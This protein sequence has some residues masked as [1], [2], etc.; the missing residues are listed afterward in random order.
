M[1]YFGNPLYPTS[2]ANQQAVVSITGTTTLGAGAATYDKQ[3]IISGAGG[4][5]ITLPAIDATNFPSRSY[6]IFNNSSATCT[7]NAA[8]A[9]TMLLLGS[10]FSSISI[11]PGERF[12]V[13]NML[14]GWVIALESASRTTTASQFDNTI[15]SASTA[16]VISAGLHYP[17]ANGQSFTANGNISISS[18]NGWGQFGAAGVTATLPALSLVPVGTTFTALGGAF[19][20][21]VAA[22]GTD[23]I[24]STIGTNSSSAV[25][26]SGQQVTFVSNGVAAGWYMAS[27]GLGIGAFG[28]SL[29]G[30]GYQKLPSGLIIQ[31]ANS[32]YTGASDSTQTFNF[33]IAFPTSCFAIAGSIGASL[34]AGSFGFQVVNSSQ[35]QVGYHN[36]SGTAASGVGYYWTAFGK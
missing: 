16:Y 33:P 10:S 7:V 13:Q 17:Q 15:R 22:N 23:T 26:I 25:L 27:S 11:L 12:L 2:P 14:T 6:S 29:S 28:S 20:G 18:M 9:D 34:G 35:F 21:T 3:F 8:G 5:T 19:G 30:S 36:T 4:Y 24:Q 32:S 31:W 1:S